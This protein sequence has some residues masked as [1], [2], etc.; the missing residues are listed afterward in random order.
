MRLMSS[1][2]AVSTGAEHT[3]PQRH[4]PPERPI[5]A[6]ESGDVYDALIASGIFTKTHPAVVTA[7]SRQLQPERFRRGRVLGAQSDCGDR[8]YVIISGKVKVSHRRSDGHE[9]VL[10]ILGPS[11]VFGLV[12]L[13]DPDSREMSVTTLTEVLALPLRRDQLL[14]LMAEHPEVGD[15]VL[16]L[17]ARWA[18]C[19]T[20]SLVDFVV[21]DVPSRIASRLLLLR[22]R[23]GRREGEV[24]RIVHDLTLEDLALLVGVASNTVD[25]TLREFERRGWIHVDGH[26]VVIV[27][28]Q[29]L[30]RL[31]PMSVPEVC[32]V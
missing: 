30:S 11:E 20:N 13:F 29:A 31:R 22:K 8:A 32:C 4:S 19:T 9:I 18:K 23:F 26:S 16:R 7:L 24:V 27:D 1:P 3:A 2:R 10:T 28:G 25:E 15:Q 17:L 14:G 5:T 21:G 12:T 6:S